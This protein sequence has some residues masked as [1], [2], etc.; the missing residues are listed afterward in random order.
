[1]PGRAHGGLTVAMNAVPPLPIPGDD[2]TSGAGHAGLLRLLADSV[3]ALIAYYEAGKLTCRFAN[4]RY[5]ETFGW[6]RESIVGHTFAEVIGEEAARLIQP[7]VDRMLQQNL[8]AV[9]ERQ[10]STSA[11]LRYVEVN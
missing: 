9:Y 8:P 2:S 10:L 7:H 1:V 5:A 4:T 6:T 11:G 3:P